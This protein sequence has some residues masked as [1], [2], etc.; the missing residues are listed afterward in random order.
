MNET[1]QA[2]A[3]KKRV[4]VRR[5]SQVGFAIG[6]LLIGIQFHRFVVF[7]SSASPT[8]LAQR[9]AAVDAWLP[10]SSFM[11]L[12]YLIRTGIANTVHPAGLVIFTLILLL[13]LLLRRGFCS[14][15]CP[16]GTLSEYAHLAGQRLFKRNLRMPKPLDI[17]L[18]SVKYLLLSLFVILICRM[19]AVDLR[20]FI[21]SPY[22]RICDVKMYAMFANPSITTLCVVTLLAFLSL[23]FKNFFCRYLCP[24]GAM[25]GLASAASP[26]AVR[27][28]SALCTR[29]AACSRACPSNIAVHTSATLRSPECTACYG[30]VSACPQPGALRMGLPGTKKT[31]TASLYL[32]ITLAAFIF[33]AQAFRAF[34]YWDT[35]TP[36]DFYRHLFTD[37]SAIG[38]PRS[39]GYLSG[40]E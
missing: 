3:H 32:V 10:I 34:G 26:T 4:T 18:R 20:A 17:I 33:T 9:P 24:Y 23:L 5:L 37:I 6:S 40:P 13:T 36:D 15:V 11:S 22:N 28:E 30:C 29:C 12:V 38:H 35:D 8:T 27:R 31:I 16:I 2:Y 39:S 21:H 1:Q 25:L 14:W 19:S 7:L